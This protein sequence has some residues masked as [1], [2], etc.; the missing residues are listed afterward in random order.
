MINHYSISPKFSLAPNSPQ[1]KISLLILQK[2]STIKTYL[3]NS[4]ISMNN[5]C[6]INNFHILS[7]MPIEENIMANPTAQN[8]VTKK[9]YSTALTFQ[10][11]NSIIALYEKDL[12]F[13]LKKEQE[14]LRFLQ[15]VQISLKNEEDFEILKEILIKS[16]KIRDKNEMAFLKRACEQL[17]YFQ[18]LK[19]NI[20]DHS[21]EECITN[22]KYESLGK[23]KL[24]FQLGEQ[25]RKIYLILKGEVTILIPNQNLP[26]NDENSN[27]SKNP[28]IRTSMESAKTFDFLIPN[29]IY[30]RSYHQGEVFGDGSLNLRVERLILILL[31]EIY[32]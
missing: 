28:S 9:R 22:L 10:T 18:D 4:C 7:S 14:Y 23:N 31:S 32:L 15:K 12:K 5:P 17:Q 24:L 21:Y 16:Q 2:N 11:H 6:N 25:G 20:D 1:A 19:E 29:Q 8:K 3:K 26:E 30:I 13:S 27:D